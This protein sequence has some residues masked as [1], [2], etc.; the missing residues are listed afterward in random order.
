MGETTQ[1]AFELREVTASLLEKEGITSGKWILAFE[2]V[3]TGGLFGTSPQ[4][5]KPG[6]MIQVNRAQLIKVPDD[7]TGNPL[8]VD[9]STLGGS[10]EEKPPSPRAAPKRGSSSKAK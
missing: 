10:P 2:F 9:A 4:D 5:S 8:V 1:Y 6:A 7:T 3:T